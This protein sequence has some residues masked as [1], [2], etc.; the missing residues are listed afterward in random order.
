MNKHI[1]SASLR[2]LSLLLI[3][4]FSVFAQKSVP[5]PKDVLGFTPGDDYKLAHWS[6]VVDYFKKL[7]ATSDR[8]MFK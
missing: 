6:K 4:S 2:L 8:V 1:V 5:E 3:L 7:D